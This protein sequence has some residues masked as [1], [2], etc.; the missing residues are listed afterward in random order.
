M[1]K[2]L[3]KFFKRQIAIKKQREK[4]LIENYDS[5]HSNWQKKVDKFENSCKKK[6]KDGK[7]RE[8]YEKMFPEIR[9]QREERERL[10]QKQ[11]GTTS[12][13]TATTTAATTGGNNINESN[14]ANIYAQSASSSSSSLTTALETS[15][16]SAA[17]TSE[18]NPIE[19]FTLG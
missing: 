18:P 12:T 8:L 7:A 14:Q 15:V 17:A 13:S 19:V 2:R 3:I 6:Q 9:K 11:K 1:N 5:L 10:L 4:S 16:T